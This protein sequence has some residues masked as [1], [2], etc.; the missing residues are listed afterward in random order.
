MS[1]EEIRE[2]WAIE[3]GTWRACLRVIDETAGFDRERWRAAQEALAATRQTMRLAAIAR[4]NLRSS[5]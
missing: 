1:H 2:I 4:R 3:R 5:E